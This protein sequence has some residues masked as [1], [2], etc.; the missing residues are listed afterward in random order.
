MKMRYA[1]KVWTAYRDAPFT[2]LTWAFYIYMFITLALYLVAPHFRRYVEIDPS[3]TGEDQLGKAL[4]ALTA[5]FSLLVAPLPTLE[6][7][8]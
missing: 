3:Q 2:T 1:E 6:T 4:A 8:A 7:E 5:I